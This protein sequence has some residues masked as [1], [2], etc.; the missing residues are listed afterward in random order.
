MNFTVEI[1]TSLF[2]AIPF[3]KD[4]GQNSRLTCESRS[5]GLN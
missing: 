5:L 2:A 4:K 1:F 3:A